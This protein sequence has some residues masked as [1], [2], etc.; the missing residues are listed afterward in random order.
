M[1]KTILLGLL[2]LV[3]FSCINDDHDD[4]VRQEV[5][6]GVAKWGAGNLR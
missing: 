5:G 2:L 4:A 6:R 1:T 3:S